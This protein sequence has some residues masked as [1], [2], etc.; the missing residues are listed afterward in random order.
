MEM[1]EGAIKER[2]KSDATDGSSRIGVGFGQRR[3]FPLRR[4]EARALVGPRERSRLGGGTHQDGGARD[5]TEKACLAPE[6]GASA[7]LES[8]GA[9]SVAR[10]KRQAAH[11]RLFF[12]FR[13]SFP[14]GR[15]QRL[16]AVRAR[17][18]SLSCVRLFFYL[19]SI[20]SLPF[21]QLY[22]FGFFL[23]GASLIGRLFWRKARCCA[24]ANTEKRECA[25]VGQAAGRKR[26]EPKRTD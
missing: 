19:F 17:A 7:R 23:G 24:S 10:P 20:F 12:Y 11:V 26:S 5:N 18:L 25:C 2:R 8:R 16:C 22:R 13:S 9:M 6:R 15:R 21:S 4:G 3:P 14:I 1:R